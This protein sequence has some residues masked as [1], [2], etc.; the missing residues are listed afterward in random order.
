VA[1]S[2]NRFHASGNEASDHEA[3]EWALRALAEEATADDRVVIFWDET[4]S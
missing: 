2:R 1:T 3:A 4:A